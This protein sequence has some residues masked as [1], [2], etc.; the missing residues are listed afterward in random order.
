MKGA[1]ARFLCYLRKT[2]KYKNQGGGDMAELRPEDL[3]SRVEQI[4]GRP[5]RISSYKLGETYH[6]KAEIDLPGAGARI[7]EASDPSR[8]AAESTVLAQV[9]ELVKT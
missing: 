3:S 2:R 8:E 4:N 6:C 7:A 9:H 1:E 5:I